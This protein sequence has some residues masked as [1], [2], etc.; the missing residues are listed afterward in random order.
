MYLDYN[1]HNLKAAHKHSIYNEN[2]IKESLLA[3]CFSCCTYFAASKVVEWTDGANGGARTALCPRCGIDSVIANRCG[4]FPIE[5]PAFV[6]AMHRHW[7][8]EHKERASVSQPASS[9]DQQ[10]LRVRASFGFKAT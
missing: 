1:E 10:Q 6:R 5:D 9:L 3:I 2:E 4:G 7:C 8:S